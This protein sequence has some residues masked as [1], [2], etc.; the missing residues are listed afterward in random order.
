MRLW[1]R[2]WHVETMVCATRGHVAP[3]LRVADVGPDDR[4]LGFE[5][6]DR[7]R[8]ARCLRCDAWVEGFAPAADAATGAGMPSLEALDLPRRGEP[9]YDA[10][11]LRLIAI[12]RGVHS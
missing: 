11:V 3:A 12:D 5:T 4:E 6:L 7:R 9:L 1:P 10:I 8:M 2:H